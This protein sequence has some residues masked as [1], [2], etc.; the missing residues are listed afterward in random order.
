[1]LRETAYNNF[2]QIYI[3]PRSSLFPCQPSHEVSSLLRDAI[4]HQLESPCTARLEVERK[5]MRG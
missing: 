5:D 3:H 2:V 4:S 1:M